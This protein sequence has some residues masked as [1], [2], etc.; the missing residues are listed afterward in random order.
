MRPFLLCVTQN[1]NE[2]HTP[3]NRLKTTKRLM[4]LGRGLTSEHFK[5]GWGNVY[6]TS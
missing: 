4:V 2:V 1:G 5:L 6:Q 3:L